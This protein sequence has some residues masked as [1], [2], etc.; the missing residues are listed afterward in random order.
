MPSGTGFAGDI[1][2]GIKS[3]FKR[4]LVTGDS[5]DITLYTNSVIQ[6]CFICANQP[7]VGNGYETG[8]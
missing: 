4:Q 7:F 1:S 5:Q 2:S 3:A 6:V 8:N